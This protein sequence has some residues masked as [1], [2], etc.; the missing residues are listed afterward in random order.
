M[1]LE[2]PT[3]VV[4]KWKFKEWATGRF[5][6]VTVK[7]TERGE[8]QTDVELTQ[9]G[10]PTADAHGHGGIRARCEG[11]WRERILGGMKRFLG[12]GMEWQD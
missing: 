8:G 10:I 9:T 7:L 5:S 4:M 1:E 11:G 2:E 3:K 12:Y 6:T